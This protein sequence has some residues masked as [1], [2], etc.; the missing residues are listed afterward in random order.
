MLLR[1]VTMWPI[2][3]LVMTPTR[4][5]EQ[6]RQALVRLPALQY[7]L[8]R[9]S[10]RFL[11]LSLAMPMPFLRATPKVFARRQLT[12]HLPKYRSA[13]RVAQEQIFAAV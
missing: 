9:L 10:P 11:L 4:A 6:V 5:P 1:F 8:R 13:L 7:R 12:V 2:T 3:I